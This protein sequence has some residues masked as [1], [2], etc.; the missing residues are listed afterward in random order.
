MSVIDKISLMV[1]N[2]DP[3]WTASWIMQAVPKA[4]VK[5]LREGCTITLTAKDDGTAFN[6]EIFL[7]FN[8]D[9]QLISSAWRQVL[10][11][12]ARSSP[13][14]GA[15]EHAARHAMLVKPFVDVRIESKKVRSDYRCTWKPSRHETL[16]LS[17]TQPKVRA[18]SREV[19]LEHTF[20]QP[21]AAIAAGPDTDPF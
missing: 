8:N 15:L 13:V 16:V 1:T 11:D 19:V 21:Y 10:P 20:N 7:T 9:A 18:L 17:S 6:R 4:T 5:K 3:T 12:L 14:S 2:A